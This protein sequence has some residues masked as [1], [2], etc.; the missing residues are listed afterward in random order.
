MREHNFFLGLNWTALLRQKAE[1]IPQLDGEDDT[2][3][4]DS[5]SDTTFLKSNFQMSSE[6]CLFKK[7]CTSL[8]I[9]H[10]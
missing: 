4:F 6:M 5:K 7:T 9:S 1:F 3:Y 10:M 2:S 8:S